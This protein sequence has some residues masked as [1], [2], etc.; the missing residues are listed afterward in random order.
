MKND[1]DIQVIDGTFS[2]DGLVYFIPLK[3]TV[4]G[5][6][7]FSISSPKHAVPMEIIDEY[8]FDILM[9][10]VLFEHYGQGNHGAIAVQH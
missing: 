3:R 1:S 5:L 7:F 2:C 8:E 10:L 4:F 6:V 9:L